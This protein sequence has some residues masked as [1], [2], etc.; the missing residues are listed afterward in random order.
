MF[1][2]VYQCDSDRGNCR[3]GTIVDTGIVAKQE[4]DFCKFML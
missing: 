2:P 1:M 4:F 3:A